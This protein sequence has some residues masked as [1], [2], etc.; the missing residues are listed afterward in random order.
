MNFRQEATCLGKSLI[1]AEALKFADAVLCD[2]AKLIK[3][4]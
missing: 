1:V 3:A 2:T 4:A